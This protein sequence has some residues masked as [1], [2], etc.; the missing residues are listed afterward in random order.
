MTVM[1]QSLCWM[2][3]NIPSWMRKRRKRSPRIS[4]SALPLSFLLTTGR[5]CRH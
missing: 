1:P 3:A 4:V 5:Q 2:F